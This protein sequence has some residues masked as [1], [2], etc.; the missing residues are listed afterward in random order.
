MIDPPRL[1]V[2]TIAN[3]IIQNNFAEVGIL[4]HGS[5]YLVERFKADELSCRELL[6]NIS[7]DL[8][9]DLSDYCLCTL[10]GF[11]IIQLD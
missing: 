9:M 6:G 4:L 5:I 10:D 2:V 7:F 3:K 8:S 1:D 11:K